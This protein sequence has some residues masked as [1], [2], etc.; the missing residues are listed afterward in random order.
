MKQDHEALRRIVMGMATAWNAGDGDGFAASFIDDA[1][2]I[3]ILGLRYTGRAAVAEA[4]RTILTTL[5]KGS[6]LA[7]AVEKIRFLRPD[8]AA[9]FLL[10][11][12]T[13]IVDGN[14]VQL[15]TRPTFI[16]HKT[17]E[18]WVHRRPSEHHGRRRG[19]RR[20]STVD[21]S[22][23][24]KGVLVRSGHGSSGDSGP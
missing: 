15:Q 16:A 3:H 10:G 9:A 14:Q 7:L 4:H 22:T 8:V 13:V 11:R 19:W 2:F 12:L 24:M 1:D 17:D 5:Y 23:G 21:V 6:H 20:A 18:A